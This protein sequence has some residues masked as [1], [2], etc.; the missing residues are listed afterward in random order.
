MANSVS[1]RK[2]EGDIPST[3]FVGFTDILD[4]YSNLIL[5]I[6]NTS[7][8]VMWISFKNVASIRTTYTIGIET[9][10]SLT[11]VV[12]GFIISNTKNKII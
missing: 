5:L 10:N 4:S 3:P 7:S 1:V 8:N 6:S 9:T 11:K 2:V 12:N